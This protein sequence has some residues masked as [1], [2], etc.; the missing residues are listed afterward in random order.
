MGESKCWQHMKILFAYQET[1]LT[2]NLFVVSLIKSLRDRKLQIDSSIDLF[3]NSDIKY[4]IIHIQWP[5]ELFRW[6]SVSKE[7]ITKLIYRINVV[8]ERPQPEDRLK[9]ATVNLGES[10]SK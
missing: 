6:K 7:D 8:Q 9:K 5:E 1:D 2:D 3:W 4:D 10:I